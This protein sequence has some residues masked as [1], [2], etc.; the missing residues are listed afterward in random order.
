M[1]EKYAGKSIEEVPEEYREFIRQMREYGYG[2][3]AI[4]LQGQM[5]EFIECNQGKRLPQKDIYR[6]GKKLKRKEMTPKEDYESR[7][8]GRWNNSEE[9]KI[10][11]E[12][13]GKPIEEVPEEYREFIEKMR[14]F[15]F[16]VEKSKL[17]Q[18]KQ[19]R[20]EAKTKNDKTKELEVQVSEELKKRGKNHEEQ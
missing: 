1:L 17:Q 7:L 5:V 11:K 3:K 13:T 10:L 14:E 2:A 16:G 19:Q 15:G 12:Y 9:K 6:D 8:R 4:T 20:D 18:I